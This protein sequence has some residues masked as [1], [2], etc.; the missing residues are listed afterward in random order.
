[1]AASSSAGKARAIGHGT[2]NSTTGKL[3]LNPGATVYTG[4]DEDSADYTPYEDRVKA[5]QSNRYALILPCL[6]ENSII[7][8]T[9]KTHRISCLYCTQLSEKDEP[10]EWNEAGDHCVICN[11]HKKLSEYT[12]RF[13]PNGGKGDMQPVKINDGEKY[14]LPS[15]RFTPTCSEYMRQAIVKHGPIKGLW[16][17]TKRLLRCHPW[18]GSGYDPV[19]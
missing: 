13:D 18:G 12:I 5:C 14:E 6:H 2:S 15:C 11:Y 17:G 19:P 1:M 9:E 10:H 3:E 7:T 8:A 16:L 4:K